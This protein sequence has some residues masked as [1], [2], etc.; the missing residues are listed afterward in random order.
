MRKLEISVDLDALRI[1]LQAI[2]DDELVNF[3]NEMKKL[4]YPPTYDGNGKPSVS[5]FSIQLNEAREEC[6]RRHPRNPK[7]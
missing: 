7:A 5:A 2:S 4:V 6:L 1:R 3:G